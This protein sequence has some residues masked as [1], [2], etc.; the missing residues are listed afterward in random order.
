MID[1]NTVV[2]TCVSYG[3]P[4]SD[5]TWSR[6]GVVLENGT[7][8]NVYDAVVNASGIPFVKSVLELCSVDIGETGIYTCTANN[9]IQSDNITAQLA[10]IF[11]LTGELDD[12]F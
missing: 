4:F 7:N 11:P 12:H 10:V 5:I 6:D 3:V 2:F 1:K 8:I 9:G